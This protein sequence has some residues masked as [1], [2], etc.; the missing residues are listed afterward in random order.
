VPRAKGLP[1]AI[2]K[3]RPSVVQLRYMLTEPSSTAAGVNPFRTGVLGSGFLVGNGYV[4]TARH[5]IEA[6]RS[7]P[8]DPYKKKAL[9][10]AVQMPVNFRGDVFGFNCDIVGEDNRHD[11]ALLKATG[12]WPADQTVRDGPVI[13]G[14]RVVFKVRGAVLSR[15]E[16]PREG[17]SIAISGYP[18]NKTVLVTTSGA[19]A[20]AWEQMQDSR[21]QDAEPWMNVRDIAD[22]YL[23]DAHI[24]PG[25]SGGPVY[26]VADGKIIGICVGIDL[27]KVIHSDEQG[28]Q[29]AKVDNRFIFYN[30]G[31][32]IAVPIKYAI[33]LLQHNGIKWDERV[34]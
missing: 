30:S 18:L 14:K 10:I 24:N 31:L 6:F 22:S 4:I 34:K 3:V 21:P 8:G 2:E 33:A 12:N 27:S 20:S 13:G 11:L 25:N 28:H 16:R 15:A 26:S 7:M 19:I 29:P 32:A 23:V 17:E 1:E 9:K 5:V